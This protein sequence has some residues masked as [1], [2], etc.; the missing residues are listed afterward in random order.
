[1]SKIN[2][3]TDADFERKGGEYFDVGVYE[4]TITS[5]ERQDPA[6]KSPYAAFDV[7]GTGGQEANIRLYLSDKATPYTLQK[8]ATIAVHNK[9]SEADKEKVRTAFKAIDDTDK[10]DDK[11]LAKFDGMQAWISVEEDLSSPKPNGGYYKNFNIFGYEPKPRVNP[12]SADAKAGET[13]DLNEIPF[14]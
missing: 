13:L 2:P 4:V 3:L 8:L 7:Q 1:M 12:I 5:T 11:F 14:D 9:T 10:I 6:G